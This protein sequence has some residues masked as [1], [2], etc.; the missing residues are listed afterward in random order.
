MGT[1]V[2][3]SV[4]VIGL[5]A[6][7]VA[8]RSRTRQAVRKATAAFLNVLPEFAAVLGL[9]GVMLTF[10]SPATIG[11]MVGAESG[12][13]GWMLASLVGSLTLIPGF[14]AFPLAA[15]LLA[16]GAGTGQMAVFI[17]TLMM[18]GIVTFPL[19]KRYFGQR[20]AVLRNG[21]AYVWSFVAAL[22]IM[23]VMAW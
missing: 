11:R 12:V 4:A 19:E 21:M 18:V 23:A 10:L 20:A 7:F 2:L 16:Q 9:V 6:S 13:A 5:G 17:S 22:A 14:V 15:S 1:I 3:Y 8:D